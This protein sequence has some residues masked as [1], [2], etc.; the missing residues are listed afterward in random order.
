MRSSF[1][2]KECWSLYKSVIG[3]N[4]DSSYP[5][6]IDNGQVVVDDELKA[7]TFNR[8]FSRNAFVDDSGKDLPD[9]VIPPDNP[10]IDHIDITFDDVMGQLS[11]LDPSKAYGPDGLG[12]RLLKELKQVIYHHYINC[13]N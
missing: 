11:A 4:K 6:L 9:G 10:T 5:S 3:I 8:L 12:P 1:S 13:S 2:S 7:N